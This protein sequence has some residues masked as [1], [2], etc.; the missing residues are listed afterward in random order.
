MKTNPAMEMPTNDALVGRVRTALHY[1]YDPFQLRRCALATQLIVGKGADP[2]EVLQRVLLDAVLALKPSLDEPPQSPAWRVYDLLNLHYI[3][4]ESADA[5]AA[6]LGVSDRQLRREKRLALEVLSSYLA[7]HHDFHGHTGEAVDDEASDPNENVDSALDS[8]LAL[9]TD[10]AFERRDPLGA[11]LQ[12]VRELVDP[13]AAR[14]GTALDWQVEADLE[15]IPVSQV[16]LR[17]LL[18]TL[19][20]VMIPHAADEPVRVTGWRQDGVASICLHVEWRALPRAD[21]IEREEETLNTARRM[22]DQYGYP[23]EIERAANVFKATIQLSSAQRIPLLVVDDNADWLDMIRRFAV[24]TAFDI[25]ALR[26]PELA[27]E[28]ASQ[29]Q[30]AAIF[31]DVMMPN[32]DGWQIVSD[33]RSDV[34]TSHIPLAVCSVL[35]LGELALSLGVNVFLQ[36]PITQEQFLTTARRL[37]QPAH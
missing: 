18:L 10:V 26:K 29:A 36:K 11:T 22:A 19:L 4:M 13:L 21:L 17:N 2:A 7:R 5:V 27:R 20:S 25:L 24:G 12:S 14:S 33:L 32:V 35:P 37:A 9:L 30:P 6:Q 34:S 3:R 1:L 8:E 23:L 31:L 16:V 28:T 15:A